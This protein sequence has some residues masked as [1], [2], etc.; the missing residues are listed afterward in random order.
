MKELR[1]HYID[2]QWVPSRSSQLIDVI[3]ATTEE[4]MAR[5]PAGTPEEVDRAV[6]AA[7]AAFGAWAA[8]PVARRAE[9]LQ[10]IAD[11][12]A[13]RS[14]EVA[15]IITAEVGMPLKLS[16]RIQ[17]AHPPQVMAS[18]A[19]LVREFQFEER[20]DNSLVVYEPVGVVGAITPWNY[21]LHQ[22][23]AKV[24]P[25]LA[26]GCTV[27]LKPSEMAPLSVYV[28]AEVVHAAGLP[29]GAFNLVCG[30]G[31]VV[32]EAIARHPDVDMVS[33]T[34][35]TRVGKRVSE[36]A[37]QTVKR[38]ALE[39]GGKSPSIVLEDADLPRAI[40]GTISSCFLNSG[41]TCTALTR[42]LVPESRYEEAAQLAVDTAKTFD[43]GYPMKED[44]RLGPLISDT[45]RERVRGFIRKGVAEGAELLLGG[46]E[47]PPGLRRGYFVQPTVFGRV[48]PGMTIEQEEIFGP[49]LSIL[50][51]KDEEDA[52]RIA[53]GTLYGLAGAVWSKDEAR[54]Q[55]VAR[56]IRAGRVQVNGG[57][58]N[59]LAPF[60]GYKQSGHGREFGR[61]GLEEFL[62]VKSLQL[63]E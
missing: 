33:F 62:E 2:G 52:V 24:A 49:V 28:L 59:L 58:Y 21:P 4:V 44:T 39:L 41:Q 16:Q 17:A 40:K 15:R 53:N 22:V 10:K 11:A 1:S 34:G 6:A 48:K 57:A 56:R 32:G 23:V 63:A 35:S 50:T 38:V 61:F 36:L 12:L 60:G 27:V 55:R 8:T 7:R 18:Y 46:A 43:P 26:A 45:Q 9:F 25:A 47:P 5:V 42:L 37:A 30:T 29:H 19:K 20:L 51:Y 14:D 13:A 31:P 54:A 3:N